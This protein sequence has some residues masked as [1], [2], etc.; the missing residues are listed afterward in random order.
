MF[1]KAIR[2]S[3]WI[4]FCSQAG[5]PCSHFQLYAKEVL[6][7]NFLPDYQ[8]QIQYRNDTDYKSC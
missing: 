4:Q 7:H 1:Y 3:W 2:V 8:T 5:V 6:L